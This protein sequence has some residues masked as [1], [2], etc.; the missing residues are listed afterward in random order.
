MVMAINRVEIKNFLV[1]KGE[2]SADFCPGANVIIGAN[3]TGKTTLIKY[4]YWW[5]GNNKYLDW[6]SNPDHQFKFTGIEH[7]FGGFQAKK[8]INFNSWPKIVSTKE[9][10]DRI[11]IPEKEMLSNSTGLLALYNKRV[12]PFEKTYIDIVENAEFPE[13]KETSPLCQKLLDKIGNIIDG[14]VVYE[15]DAFYIKKKNGE[16]FHFSWEASGFRK[17]G[18]LW[19]LLRNGLL[20]KESLLFWDEPENSLNPELIPVLVDILLELTR[21]SVQVFLA[22]HSEILASYFNIN[23]QKGD[24]VMFYSLY[25]DENGIIKADKK[26]RFDLLDPNNLTAEPVKLYEKELEKGLGNG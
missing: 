22:T 9:I 10:Y 15:Q 20:E 19:K 26:N 12:I 2:F 24:T 14:E 1:F 6:E 17:F 3:G 16:R 21:N 11:Y 7:Y 23:K 5:S 8:N 25:K 4:L 18:L 13:T